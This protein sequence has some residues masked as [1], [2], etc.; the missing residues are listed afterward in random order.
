MQRSLLEALRR[1]D[2]IIDLYKSILVSAKGG[3]HETQNYIFFMFIRPLLFYAVF[4]QI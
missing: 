1:E 4:L 2:R 3:N